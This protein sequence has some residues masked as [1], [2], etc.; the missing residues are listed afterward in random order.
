[1]IRASRSY[2]VYLKKSPKCKAALGT[3]TI[4]RNQSALGIIEADE[5]EV[6]KLTSNFSSWGSLRP[7][8][9]PDRAFHKGVGK[10]ALSRSNGLAGIIG[11]MMVGYPFSIDLLE[12][13]C[14]YYGIYRLGLAANTFNQKHEVTYDRQME[15]TR[16]RE[17]VKRG[18]YNGYDLAH[19]EAQISGMKN[20]VYGGAVLAAGCNATVA[21]L[22]VFNVWLY[23]WIY[24]TLKRK[25]WVNTQI[26][27]LV[28]A[29]P[30]LMG[31][32]TNTGGEFVN[33]FW[34]VPTGLLFFWQFPHF[35]GLA[36]ERNPE[37]HRAGY[38]MLGI[39]GRWDQVWSICSILCFALLLL[40]AHE[41]LSKN[42]KITPCGENDKWL[43]YMP[44][45]AIA[46]G[47]SIMAYYQ[48]QW[49]LGINSIAAARK[50]FWSSTGFI[51]ILASLSILHLIHECVIDLKDLEDNVSYK[52]FTILPPN[53]H[54]HVM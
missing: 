2:A 4:D 47:G 5:S 13:G 51:T 31:Y 36:V 30:P 20:V 35:Y 12:L 37:Y 34:I 53:L 11:Y 25:S 18:S 33:N 46:M 8:Y 45:V 43:R 39:T 15:R 19:Y 24:T 29:I 40:F 49:T 22:G 16:L 7:S 42:E 17:L 41:E 32:L 6:R 44:L 9:A 28:G 27:A 21:G 50:L 10:D 1:M 3:K 26:G 38:K 23:Y 52:L 54:K 14:L 48:A